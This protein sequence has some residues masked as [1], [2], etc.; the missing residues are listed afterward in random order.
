MLD[1]ESSCFDSFILAILAFKVSGMKYD[2]IARTLENS[3]DFHTESSVRHACKKVA[4]MV[5]KR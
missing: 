2:G 1:I 3:H 5:K 4:K